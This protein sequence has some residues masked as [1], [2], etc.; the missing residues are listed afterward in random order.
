MCNTDDLGYAYVQDV[1]TYLQCN[2][3]ETALQTALHELALPRQHWAGR[4]DSEVDWKLAEWPGPEGGVQWNEVWLEASRYWCIPEVN[5]GENTVQHLHTKLEGV[6]D[7][8]EGRAA[9]QKDL[10]RLEKWAD[11]N[12]MQFNKGK[13][14]LLHLGRNKPMHQYMLGAKWL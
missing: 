6:A 4:A 10:D 14:K 11:R 12:L 9:I 7:T 1:G 8:P 5:T 13:C 2:W 3:A